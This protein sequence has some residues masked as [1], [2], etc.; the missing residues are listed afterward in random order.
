M[1]IIHYDPTSPYFKTPT[2]A[3][4][5]N[6]ETRIYMGLSE[7]YDVERVYLVLTKDG[8]ESVWYPMTPYGEG[9]EARIT[10]TTS[11]LY[12][13]HFEVRQT[14]GR[15]FNIFADKSLYPV[16]HFGEEWVLLCKE[17]AYEF[18]SALAGGVIYQIMVDRFCSVGRKKT[19]RDVVY[20]DDWEGTPYY[21]ADKEGVVR[22]DDMFGG[23]LAGITSK[24][25]YLQALGVTCIYLNPIFEAH[26]NHKYDT[27]NYLRIDPDFGSEEDLKTLVDE[28]KKRGIGVM[29]DGVFSHTGDDSVYFNKYGK[30]DSLGAYQSVKSPYYDW[31]S[32]ISHPTVYTS[33]WGINI[34]PAVNETNPDFLKFITG[35]DGVVDKYTKMG[36][37]GWRLDVADELPDGFLD[38]L[39][40]RVKTVNPQALVLGEVWEDAATK[41]AYGERR[42]YLQGKQLESVTNYPIRNAIVAFEKNGDADGL[43]LT[44]R[45]ILDHYPDE[46]AHSLMNPLGTHDTERVLTALSEDEAP[47]LKT[48][49]E[50]APISDE[51]TAKQK[52]KEAFGLLFTL[53]GVPCVYYGDEA[54]MQG[55]EDPFNR[56]CYPWGKEDKTLVAFVSSL[57]RLRAKYKEVFAT[58]R[59]E[60][61]PSP[62]RTFRFVRR[63]K[64]CVL[65]IFVNASED[66]VERETTA[67]N[68]LNGR[69]VRKI[70]P[71]SV[72]VTRADAE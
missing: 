43:D 24:L 4:T 15:F 29:L 67:R 53:P 18:S 2:G 23:N 47:R 37:V 21:L 33:W 39:T 52:V 40:Q 5:Q 59:Y 9:Y 19:K 7:R 10:I 14:E 44:V 69:Y 58:G 27:G 42:R 41:I 1:R 49:R 22:N 8:E 60:R 66:V 36:I 3:A 70:Q 57:G 68:L 46:V 26:S 12:F 30:Y 48:E 63:T 20:R 64:D 31:Y 32:F 71:H 11:G 38:A 17:N 34:L 51:E 25:P 35:E 16:Y 6:E 61:Y 45:T 62:E 65:E 56:R 55:Y 28:A 13:Y 54:G 72:V 50:N